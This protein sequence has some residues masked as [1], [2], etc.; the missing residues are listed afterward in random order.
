MPSPIDATL[1][2]APGGQGAPMSLVNA[3]GATAAERRALKDVKAANG[4]P[5][6]TAPVTRGFNTRNKQYVHVVVELPDAGTSLVWRMYTWD[7]TSE[8][9]TLE[10]TLGTA[11]D[12]ALAV[13]DSPQRTIVEIDAATRVYIELLTFAGVFTE[14]ASVWLSTVG[15]MSEV[16]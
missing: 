13:A 2:N 1:A 15:D 10:T 8:R 14:G 7:A 3:R 4:A 9:W 16:G 5:S 11:G 6:N 12:V